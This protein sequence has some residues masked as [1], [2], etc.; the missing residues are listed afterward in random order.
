MVVE[1]GEV[2]EQVVPAV[3]MQVSLPDVDCHVS[4]VDPAAELVAVRFPLR[5]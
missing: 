4:D 5:S 1:V 2:V 3:L